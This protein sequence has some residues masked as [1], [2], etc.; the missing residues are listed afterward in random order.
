MAP[1]GSQTKNEWGGGQTII[2]DYAA[3]QNTNHFLFA[4]TQR[5]AELTSEPYPFTE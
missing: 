2:I 1:K 5:S 4:F 3:D